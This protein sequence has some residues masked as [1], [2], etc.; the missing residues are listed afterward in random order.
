M[1][2]K[3]NKHTYSWEF[4]IKVVNY[5][6]LKIRCKTLLEPDVVPPIHGNQVSKPLLE[7]RRKKSF[8]KFNF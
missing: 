8:L 7:I 1:L 3:L 4:R 2:N 5:F 6:K